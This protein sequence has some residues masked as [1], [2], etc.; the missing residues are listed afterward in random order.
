[1]SLLAMHAGSLAAQE[2]LVEYRIVGD[3]IPVPLTAVPG[4]P[5][6][7]RQI[8]TGRDGNCILC[9]AFPAVAGER[10]VAGDIAPPLAGV[11]A[12]LQAGQLRLRLVDSTRLN[13]AT[14]MP[15]Y[16]RIDGLN[17]VASAFQGKP[18]LGA[19]QIE[20]AVAYLQTL[21]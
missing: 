19:Q 15:A 11:G 6:K 18:V 12:R 14:V 21:R 20:D 9:H 3:S 7:G 8:V 2:S 16:Y 4:D 13:P 5:A 1:M 17:R 10:S